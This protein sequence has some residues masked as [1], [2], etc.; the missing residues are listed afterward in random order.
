VEHAAAGAAQVVPGRG[1]TAEIWRGAA[2]LLPPDPSPEDVAVALA[3]LNE[4]ARRR[5][6]AAAARRRASD[7]ALAPEPVAAALDRVLR[8][9]V[10][11]RAI[12][13]RGI[14]A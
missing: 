8:E 11:G 3:A 6:L 5:T 13:T 7:P 2:L 10:A 4:P 14:S 9:A 1:A 12:G